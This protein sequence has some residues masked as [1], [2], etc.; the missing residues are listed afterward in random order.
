VPRAALRG[1]SG[2]AAGRACLQLLAE[3]DA[4][5]ARVELAPAARA[6]SFTGSKAGL[7]E[8]SRLSWQEPA[9]VL[10][11][12]QRAWLTVSLPHIAMHGPAVSPPPHRCAQQTPGRARGHAV[13]EEDARKRLRHHHLCA[14]APRAS[15]H[16]GKAEPSDDPKLLAHFPAPALSSCSACCTRSAQGVQSSNIDCKHCL[17]ACL[18][19]STAGTASLLAAAPPT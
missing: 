10:A 8:R 11:E 12:A 19:E 2:R 1:G 18:A 14:C 4:R 6:D 17:L 13:P 9:A 15:Q 7:S 3:P 5:L 16:Q